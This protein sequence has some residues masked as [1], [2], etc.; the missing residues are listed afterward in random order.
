ML[1]R[2]FEV[3]VNGERLMTSG[4][5]APFR[6]YTYNSQILARIP[7]RMVATGLLVVALRVGI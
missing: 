4:Q 7:D 3:Y 1:A 5:F 2:A 6:P